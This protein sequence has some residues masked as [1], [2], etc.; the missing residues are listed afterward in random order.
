MTTGASRRCFPDEHAL[1]VTCPAQPRR[2]RPCRIA[3]GLATGGYAAP[4][5]TRHGGF[6][7]A[8]VELRA[9]GYTSRS[10]QPRATS[11]HMADLPD[12]LVATR[13]PARFSTNAKRSVDTWGYHWAWHPEIA[14]GNII[15][16]PR[17]HLGGHRASARHSRARCGHRS[18]GRLPGAAV[19]PA[20]RE[21]RRPAEVGRGGRRHEYIASPPETFMSSPVIEAEASDARNTAAA[22]MSS[23]GM[24]RRSGVVFVVSS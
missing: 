9:R 24:R 20:G 21:G 12:T 17:S 16:R 13:V 8:I 23:G 2:G 4:G 15:R 3:A 1:A 22:A 7:D 19:R 14:G 11:R 10:W 6:R 5:L 18:R